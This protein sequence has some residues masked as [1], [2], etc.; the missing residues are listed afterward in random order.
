[1]TFPLHMHSPPRFNEDMTSPCSGR[2]DTAGEPF[3][4]ENE[5]RP[6]NASS[7]GDDEV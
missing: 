5:T 6:I 4:Q 1:M 3:T 2:P 7:L